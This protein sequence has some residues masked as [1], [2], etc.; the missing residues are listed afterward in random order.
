MKEIEKDIPCIQINNKYKLNTYY[1]WAFKKAN[2]EKLVK[3][4]YNLDSYHRKQVICL[5]SMPLLLI[6]LTHIVR[7]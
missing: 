6:Y 2:A 5:S 3:N 7:L 1:E 4:Q